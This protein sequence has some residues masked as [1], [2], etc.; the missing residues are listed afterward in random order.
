MQ[1]IYYYEVK[2]MFL[3]FVTS[4]AYLRKCCL[5]HGFILIGFTQLLCFKLCFACGA[6]KVPCSLKTYWYWVMLTSFFWNNILATLN[7]LG[8]GHKLLVALCV[9]TDF[10]I[11]LLFYW[12]IFL[13]SCQYYYFLYKVIKVL[14]LGK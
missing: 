4:V 10:K 12:S 7:C 1:V 2:I 5:H 11:I 13:F 8:A 9:L 14:K 6:A 3:R